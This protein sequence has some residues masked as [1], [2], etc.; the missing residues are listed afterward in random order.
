MSGW[1]TIPAW[2]GVVPRDVVRAE[3]GPAPD[4]VAPQNVHAL[5]RGGV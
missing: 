5:V 2:A 1:L 4:P 3:G